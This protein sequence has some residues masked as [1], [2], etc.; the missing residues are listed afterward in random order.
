[1]CEC[2]RKSMCVWVHVHVCV[3]VM[4]AWWLNKSLSLL[5]R[6]ELKATQ[7]CVVHVMHLCVCACVCGGL[8]VLPPT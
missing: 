3:C 5:S 4:H 6:V 7:A 8:P 1:M 2:V